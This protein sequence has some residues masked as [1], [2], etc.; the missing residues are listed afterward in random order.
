MTCSMQTTGRRDD[1]SGQAPTGR[2]AQVSG[3]GRVDVAGFSELY[4]RH[5]YR[6]FR[7]CMHR[8]FDR[9]AAEDATSSVFLKAVEGFSRFVGD[10]RDF[11]NWLYAI[12]TNL[13]NSQCRRN[14]LW[15]RFLQL[16][17]RSLAV[18]QQDAADDGDDFD[19]RLA[20][21]RAAMRELKPRQQALITLRFFEGLD[22][23]EITQILGG[24]PATVRSQL[25]RALTTLRRRMRSAGLDAKREV[26]PNV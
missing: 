9:A 1:M 14:R 2:I 15:L 7:Y 12:A 18:R 13:L 4:R 11:R 24:S 23:M 3:A 21:L 20:C 8:L 10:E 22:A 25:S 19:Q 17:G 26:L 16:R 6:V 5:Y